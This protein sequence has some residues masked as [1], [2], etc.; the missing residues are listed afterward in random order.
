MAWRRSLSDVEREAR[1]LAAQAARAL[2]RASGSVLDADGLPLP[3]EALGLP[4]AAVL[5]IQASGQLLYRLA[6]HDPAED[7]DFR[8]K[9]ERNRPPFPNEDSIV[10]GGLSM[11]ATIDQA[12]DGARRYPKL[13]AAVTLHEGMGFS[14]AKTY[15]PG[16]YTVWGDPQA[17]AGHAEVVHHDDGDQ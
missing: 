12:L 6:W 4:A 11:F 10:H 9:R 13:V 1:R 2:A 15:G 7:G 16:H 5:A 17:L 3:P 8:T 14:L